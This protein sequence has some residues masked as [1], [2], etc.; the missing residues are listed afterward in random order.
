MEICARIDAMAETI[1]AAYARKPESGDLAGFWLQLAEEERE[2]AAAWRW[3]GRFVDRPTM[4]SYIEDYDEALKRLEE[5]SSQAEALL[6]RSREGIALREMFADTCTLELGMLDTAFIHLF[7]LFGLL[8]PD[9][10]RKINYEAH[11]RHFSDRIRESGIA[12]ELSPMIDRIF[13]FWK[14]NSLLTEQAQRDYLTGLLNRRGFIGR[15]VPLAALIGRSGGES[16]FLMIDI[17][18][19]KA[20]NDTHGHMVGDAVLSRLGAIVSGHLRISDAAGRFGGEEFTVFLP[21][22]GAQGAREAAEKL[23]KAVESDG[24]IPVPIT[25]SVGFAWI[26]HAG[27]AAGEMDR[28]MKTADEN[29]YA[30]KRN[31]RNRTEGSPAG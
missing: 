11:I 30:A 12:S 10:A 8:K 20:V 21:E 25:V 18:R 19:F 2:H 4:E 13:Q 14:Q 16:G 7:S 26:T 3:L 17:D 1:Y 9:D 29:L 22:T 24:E 31:G 27:N 6:A 5:L 28:L 23:R 15:T